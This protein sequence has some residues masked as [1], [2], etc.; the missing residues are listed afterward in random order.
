M[1]RPSKQQRYVILVQRCKVCS[2]YRDRP[3]DADDS[4]H[5]CEVE[6]I[7]RFGEPD[8]LGGRD[9]GNGGEIAPVRGEQ[10][11]AAPR[12]H[13]RA[14][15][16]LHAV[17]HDGIRGPQPRAPVR[18]GESVAL[19]A[20]PVR[21][22]GGYVAIDPD[23]VADENRGRRPP[24]PKITLV[25]P[26]LAIVLGDGQRE[27]VGPRGRV[28][29]AG[30]VHEQGAITGPAH[31]RGIVHVIARA[32]QDHPRPA[33]HADL[34]DGVGQIHDGCALNVTPFGPGAAEPQPSAKPRRRIQ[35]E[36]GVTD[37]APGHGDELEFDGV[38]APG[39]EEKEDKRAPH[40][41]ATTTTARHAARYH[42]SRGGR[43][44][45]RGRR[46]RARPSTA[47]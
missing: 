5:P 35:N 33:P 17:D 11:L 37:H 43:E 29:G 46:P 23:L 26:G 9:G 18:G 28:V 1:R 6:S 22:P 16:V 2:T 3:V 7:D 38:G 19:S 12:R 14:R 21:R 39:E 44:M 20:P 25:D 8:H 32:R 36:V 30:K 15:H 34:V 40:R 13:C 4:L 42:V 10:K 47:T 27:H 45:P 24:E 31:D 41:R